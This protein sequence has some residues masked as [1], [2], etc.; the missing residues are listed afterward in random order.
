MRRWE[1]NRIV[2]LDSEPESKSSAAP[3]LIVQ[4]DGTFPPRAHVARL[5]HRHAR[6]RAAQP[7]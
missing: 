5:R 3:A 6:V 7:G 2:S 1:K 4:D